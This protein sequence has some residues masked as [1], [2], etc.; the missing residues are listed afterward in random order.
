MRVCILGY[1]ER[2]LFDSEEMVLV[3]DRLGVQEVKPLVVDA[4]PI[5]CYLVFDQDQRLLILRVGI[6]R[7]P[8]ELAQD[9][10]CLNSRYANAVGEAVQ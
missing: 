9:P 10:A 1:Y 5:V 4:V 7:D 8:D 3:R 2:L 6:E